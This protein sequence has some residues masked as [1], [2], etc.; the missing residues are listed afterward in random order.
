MSKQTRIAKRTARGGSRVK[1][2]A[3]A[4][5]KG[6]KAVGKVAVK[7]VGDIALAPMT[8]FK[9]AMKKL[10]ESK[11][12]AMPKRIKNVDLLTKFYNEI[13]VKGNKNS[14]LD[15]NWYDKYDAFTMYKDE[16][17]MLDGDTQ[18]N[19]VNDIAM[20]LK[21]VIQ[22]FSSKN[23]EVKAVELA[24]QKE[25]ISPVAAA[26]KLG[27]KITDE[28]VVAAETADNIKELAN[29]PPTQR[30]A[31]RSVQRGGGFL[32]GINF[33]VSS[34]TPDYTNIVAIGALLIVAYFIF[35]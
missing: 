17:D 7:T 26:N 9:P 29:T 6:I 8:P 5:G 35:K 20:I 32:S 14:S 2:A 34:N 1:V 23:K 3:K 19:L 15:R 33:G 28:H 31:V 25:G 12:H 11:G 22:W 21:A 24:A 18:D 10:L 27:L 16:F 4:V 13:V 30:G